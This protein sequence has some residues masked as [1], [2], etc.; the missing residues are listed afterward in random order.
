MHPASSVILCTSY[1]LR[2]LE[3]I[4]S[5][6]SPTKV[7]QQQG[8]LE[9][10]TLEHVYL[11]HSPVFTEHAAPVC[12]KGPVKSPSAYSCLCAPMLIHLGTHDNKPLVSFKWQNI[13]TAHHQSYT[14]QRS[15]NSPSAALAKKRC[16]TLARD[17]HTLHFSSGF[18]GV[19]L[20]HWKASEKAWKFCRDPST[21]VW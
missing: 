7:F 5:G 6:K 17:Y 3:L 11:I 14:T 4:Y 20:W 19:P 13:E 21:L 1:Q 10:I 9:V 8:S 18:M 15:G 2:R 12:E 16:P